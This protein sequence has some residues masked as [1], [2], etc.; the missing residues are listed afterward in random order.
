PSVLRGRCPSASRYAGNCRKGR[1]RES[2]VLEGCYL[3]Q[4]TRRGAEVAKGFVVLCSAE[5]YSG[6]GRIGVIRSSTFHTLPWHSVLRLVRC[7]GVLR[8]APGGE[9]LTAGQRAANMK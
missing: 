4:R 9:E 5:C 1:R 7:F 6:S 3:S 2:E 8:V